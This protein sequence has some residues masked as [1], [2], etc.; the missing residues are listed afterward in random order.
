MQRLNRCTHKR[1]TNA[2]K[3][4]LYRKGLVHAAYTCTQMPITTCMQRLIP[5][6][7]QRLI[8]ARKEAHTCMQ[9]IHEWMLDKTL[10]KSYVISIRVRFGWITARK[11][12]PWEQFKD[13]YIHYFLLN[14]IIILYHHFILSFHYNVAN[15]GLPSPTFDD[16]LIINVSFDDKWDLIC[17]CSKWFVFQHTFN[18]F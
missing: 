17:I 4:L 10:T 15:R 7:T 6:C 16:E 18:S 3:R 13:T 2:Y 11:H 1:I 8:Y 14:N 9:E 5:T 12:V